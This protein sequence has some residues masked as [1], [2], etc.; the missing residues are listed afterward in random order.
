MKKIAMIVGMGSSVVF[1]YAQA[2]IGISTGVAAWQ[3]AR[4]TLTPVYTSATVL[5]AAQTNSLWADAPGGSEWISSSSTQGTSCVVGQTP[6][7]GCASALVN[8]NGDVW[9][10]SLTINA[11]QLGSTSGYVTFVFGSD[12]R[13]DIHI[14]NGATVQTWNSS[15]PLGC[16]GPT[17]PTSA[18]SSQA[19]YNTCVGKVLFNASNL[20][21]DGSLTLLAQVHNDPIQG[22]S[23]CGDPT[24]FV[25]R[26]AVVTGDDIFKNGFDLVPN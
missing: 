11:A 21:G 26:G 8:V 9:N 2:D 7:N 6:G 14:G 3:V 18:G 25:L 4:D 19:T 17:G 10:Y 23:A 20:N 12:N 13:V 22:C 16:S 24:G 5:T 15:G 1:G